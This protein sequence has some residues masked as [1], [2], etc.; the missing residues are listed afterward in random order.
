MKTLNK[1]LL[2]LLA[3]SALSV[4]ANAAL[5]QHM[6]TGQPYVGLKAGQIMIDDADNAGAF[7]GFVGYQ[8]DPNWGVE[9][10]YVGSTDADTDFTGLEYNA[11]TYG[12]YGTYKYG[13]ANT[14]AYVKGKLGLA[15]SEVEY[16][17]TTTN[18]SITGDKTGIAG[19][20]GLGYNVSPNMALEASY[21]M[22][23]KAEYNDADTKV[24]MWSIG[25]NYKF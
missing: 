3:T 6:G 11:K 19:G 25:A 17:A 7:G 24:D 2:A 23:P 22:L 15:K 16:T 18:R 14:P 21:D 8:F 4:G 12:A 13:F 5:Y 10:E 1:T 20:L 9:A